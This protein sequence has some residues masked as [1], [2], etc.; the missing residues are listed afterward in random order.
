MTP[1]SVPNAP[2]GSDPTPNEIGLPAPSV[3]SRFGPLAAALVAAILA[4][5]VGATAR[6]DYDATFTRPANWGKMGAYEQSN[7]ISGQHRRSR[8]VAETRNTAIAFGTLAAA[9]ALSLAWTGG[10]LAGSRPLPIRLVV[11]LGMA[12]V[13]AGVVAGVTFVTVPLF[14]EHENPETGL[15]VPG[16]IHGAFA[17]V[18]GLVGGLALGLGRGGWK[19]AV[20]GGAGG[21]FGAIIG[22]VVYEMI[23]SVAFPLIRLE[24]PLPPETV[25]H[26]LLHLTIVLPVA[27]LAASF[28]HPKGRK[29]DPVP[30][31][32]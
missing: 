21:L 20:M 32:A 27:F 9:L 17:A 1:E 29:P 6:A 23:V 13:G 26:L 12:L 16:L 3:A 7:Y 11:G 19:A 30:T 18:V 4:W 15:L 24:S 25:P 10:W 22:V 8:D 31:L 2:N 5:Q 14:Y 28:A